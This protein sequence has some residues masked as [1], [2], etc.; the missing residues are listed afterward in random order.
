MSKAVLKLA[1][2]ILWGGLCIVP[3]VSKAESVGFFSEIDYRFELALESLNHFYKRDQFS[4]NDQ[5]TFDVEAEFL[6]DN[7][8]NF[9]IDLQPRLRVDFND[10]NR[11][12]YI[13]N[14]A[15]LMSYGSHHQ[16]YAG[17][18]LKSYGVSTFF[19]PT[20][21][22]TRRDLG[23]N[24]YNPDLLGEAIV[25]FRF[26]K[27][28]IGFLND[29]SLEAMVMPFFQQVPLPSN[30]SRFALS[31]NLG[32]LPFEL[33]EGQDRPSYL[34]SVG[35]GVVLSAHIGIFDPKLLYYHGPDRTTPGFYLTT[36]STGA[37]KLRPFYYNID[38]VG[39]NF[40]VAIG[41]FILHFEGAYKS[42]VANGFRTHTVGTGTE[43][44]IPQSYFQYVPGVDFKLE[45]VF[46]GSLTFTLEYYGEN[47]QSVELEEFRPFKNDLFF[48]VLY[49]FNNIRLTQIKLGVLKDLSNRELVALLD[50]Q[51]KL[52]K[53][54]KIQVQGLYIG[55]DSDS[56]APLSFFPNNSYLMTR[57][58]YSFG[59]K[60]KDSK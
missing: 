35:A 50:F 7:R 51:S 33:S 24:V 9:K 31:G 56:T 18:R 48:G 47:N 25:G 34:S 11:N 27:E 59:G 57:L 26:L 6:F 30:E 15:Y 17:L 14:N 37:L 45:D 40:E 36:S 1:A 49:D 3:M 29:L 41:K 13:P 10:S 54:L 5:F 38:M 42:T 46:S 39:L 4:K 16:V 32:I 23:D 60:I 19:N 2:M 44:Q 12:R 55:Q 22:F 20:D 52:Y 28:K 43:N 21:V 8:K 53:Q 58:S